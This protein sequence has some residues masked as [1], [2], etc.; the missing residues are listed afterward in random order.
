MKRDYVFRLKL[1]FIKSTPDISDK[2]YTAYGALKY[3]S[4][5]IIFV[6]KTKKYKLVWY[7]HITHVVDLMFING[8]NKAQEFVDHKYIYSRT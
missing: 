2:T 6:V 7:M 3:I 8:S 1:A 5:L 4:Y